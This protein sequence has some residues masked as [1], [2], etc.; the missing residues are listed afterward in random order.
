VPSLPDSAPSA[1]SFLSLSLPMYTMPFATAGTDQRWLG[2][3]RVEFQSEVLV[4][5]CQ[6]HKVAVVKQSE[7]CTV[8]N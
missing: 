2:Q 4:V 7:P 5:E 6:A 1:C 3:R 8:R